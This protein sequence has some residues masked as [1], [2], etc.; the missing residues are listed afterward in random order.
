[1][2]GT[3]QHEA[4]LHCL[5]YH[6]DSGLTVDRQTQEFAESAYGL[7][8]AD[9]GVI[10][11]DQEHDAREVLLRLIFS[12]NEAL[13]RAVE[14]ILCSASFSESEIAVIGKCLCRDRQSVTLVFEDT[15]V[16]VTLPLDE[17]SVGMLIDHLG[18]DRQL[19]ERLCLVLQ[20]VVAEPQVLAARSLLRRRKVKLS[21]RTSDFLCNFVRLAGSWPDRFDSLFELIITLVTEKPAGTA[22]E[23]YLL[24]KRSQLFRT[25]REIETFARKSEQ[26]GLE[27]LLMQRYPVPPESDEMVR[28]ELALLDSLIFDVLHLEIP[29]GQPV[30][31]RD[32]GQFN[33]NVDDDLDQL[34]R[35]LS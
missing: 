33:V 10:L 20:E 23:H 26:Y 3:G 35:S 25:L 18:I 34:L 28:R 2:A 12:P 15:A 8:A 4:L 9:L 13:R 32:Y 11:L 6:L 30:D 16:T 1:M 17:E 24:T 7:T 21:A 19:D 22:M 29:T 14:D 27:L 31:R 5:L